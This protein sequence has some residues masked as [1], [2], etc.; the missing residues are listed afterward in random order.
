MAYND[1]V[2]EVSNNVASTGILFSGSDSV[3]PA[4]EQRHPRYAAA[5]IDTHEVTICST[6]AF[7]QHS[8]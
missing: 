1:Y 3:I 7:L 8:Y 4:A 2:L 5:D 6:L